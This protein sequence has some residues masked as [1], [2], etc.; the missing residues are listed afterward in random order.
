MHYIVITTHGVAAYIYMYMCVLDI[1]VFLSPIICHQNNTL[2][3]VVG[4]CGM[5][6][7]TTCASCRNDLRDIDT[8]N[9]L[10]VTYRLGF[11]LTVTITGHVAASIIVI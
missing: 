8:A 11:T 10:C 3:T 6:C 2:V 9:N 7:V 4:H 5:Y 1:R